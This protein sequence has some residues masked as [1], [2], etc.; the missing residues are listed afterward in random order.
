MDA[1]NYWSIVVVAL[2]SVIGA[3]LSGR[4]AKKATQITTEASVTNSKMLAETE[5]YA[6]A[7]KMDVETINRQ[8]EEIKEIQ[9]NNRELRE[10]I[11]ELKRDNER[12]HKENLSLRERVTRLEQGEYSG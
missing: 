4:A 1:S 10:K 7:R 12:M 11:R 9:Q 3:V 6:R 5:A 2:T 8:D